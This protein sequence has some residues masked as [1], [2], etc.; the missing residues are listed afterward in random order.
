M[1]CSRENMRLIRRDEDGENHDT[2]FTDANL[3]IVFACLPGKSTNANSTML[4]QVFDQIRARANPKDG[5]VSLTE[6]FSEWKPVG[7]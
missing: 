4:Q 2:E 5:Q 6:A 7:G 3:C 1:D